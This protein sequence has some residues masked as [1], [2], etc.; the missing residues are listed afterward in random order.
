[1]S[2]HARSDACSSTAKC[3]KCGGPVCP[4]CPHG[5]VIIEVELSAHTSARVQRCKAC[6]NAFARST[7]DA[8]QASVAADPMSSATV[9][10]PRTRQ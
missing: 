10:V 9:E 6:L 3:M 1:M 7:F 2:Y 5:M 4:I 8:W